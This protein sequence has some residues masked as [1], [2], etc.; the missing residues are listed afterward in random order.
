MDSSQGTSETTLRPGQ[1]VGGTY[2]IDRLIGKGGMAAVWE[3]T[4]Q[5]TGKRVALKVI[6]HS[7]ASS[8]GAA[9][10]L[11]REALAASR[12]NHPNVVNVFDVIEH[13]H[14]A[15]IV[16]EM[17]DGEPFSAYLARKGFLAIDE[18]AAL[19]L[20]AMRGVAAAN[21][22]GVIHRDLKPQ[23]IFICIG[24]DG[25]MLTT[26]V[27]DFG[28]S[29]MKEEAWRSPR[30]AALSATHG[31]PAY[32]SPEHIQGK[33]DLDARADVYGFGVLLFEALTGQLPFLG[34]PGPELLARIVN[35]P[36]PKVGLFRPDLPA[37]VVA[38]VERAMA[39]D[40]RDR[41]PSLDPFVAALEDYL[42]QGSPL[43]RALTPMAGVPLFAQHEQK[44]GVADQVAQV[45]YRTEPLQPREAN[46]TK[47]LFTL[48]RE[49]EGGE[50]ESSQRVVV[51]GA[52]PSSPRSSI[53]RRFGRRVA[54]VAMFAGMLLVVGW[55]SFPN[56]PSQ[57]AIDEP[58][59]PQAAPSPMPEEL[60]TGGG[61]THPDGGL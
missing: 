17:L 59:V 58:P 37:P 4:S 1:I 57:Q 31:T 48:P 52:E 22:L 15:C 2:R 27:L 8:A 53:Q 14:L 55:L 9:E 35:G 18:A 16:M 41:F 43:P 24:A 11:R 39:R 56:L 20:P 51:V 7:F 50:G 42:M 23:N 47:S 32:M 5:R 60:S 25:R 49:S 21:A 10:M 30:I 29:V 6:L 34:E 13:E 33:H 26:K 45:V 61:I 36:A 44:S 28:I 38:I 3:G 46:D 19:L 40:P 54:S 12:V